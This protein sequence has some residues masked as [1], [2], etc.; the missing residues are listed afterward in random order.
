M[1]KF[2]AVYCILYEIDNGL[3]SKKNTDGLTAL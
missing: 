3:T 1:Q 2:S